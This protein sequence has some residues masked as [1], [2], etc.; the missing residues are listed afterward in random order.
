MKTHLNEL[1]K[2]YKDNNNIKTNNFSSKK[3]ISLSNLNRNNDCKNKLSKNKSGLFLNNFFQIT[4]VNNI[5]NV[6]VN[7]SFKKSTDSINTLKNFK[8]KRKINVT[9]YQGINNEYIFGLAMN[10]LNRYQENILLKENN[11]V[12]L[13]ILL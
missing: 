11:E 2:Q 7:N 13:I 4:N 8:K 6:K 9:P 10:N 5:T 1:N 3:D 12:I